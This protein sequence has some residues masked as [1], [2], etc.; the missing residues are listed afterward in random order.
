VCSLEIEGEQI[1][2]ER[3][4]PHCSDAATGCPNVCLA[5][6]RRVGSRP[7]V[8]ATVVSRASLADADEFTPRALPRDEQSASRVCCRG[9]LLFASG[10]SAAICRR[11]EAGVAL[12]HCGQS[13]LR[14]KPG[15]HRDAR[16][17]VP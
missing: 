8:R 1:T 4:Q 13:T 9:Q 10:M 14:A 11:R 15:V 3:N 6:L 12:E 7:R 5:R 16:D 2:R 17:R